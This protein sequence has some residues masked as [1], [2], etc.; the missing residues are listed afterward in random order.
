M[1]PWRE[2]VTAWAAGQ[3]PGG[4]SHRILLP[5]LLQ[6]WTTIQQNR[7]ERISWTHRLWDSINGPTRQIWDTLASSGIQ[8]TH[9]PIAAEM[10]CDP[11]WRSVD[12]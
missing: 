12:F 3:T 4:N 9:S 7:E 8:Y 2:V 5:S 11:Y 1:D 10:N 6:T